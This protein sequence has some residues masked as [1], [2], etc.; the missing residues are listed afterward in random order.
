MSAREC[1][2]EGFLYAESSREQ[3]V[4]L[5]RDRDEQTRTASEARERFFAV[6]SHELRAALTPLVLAVEA[7]NREEHDPGKLRRLS[8]I[9]RNI[10]AQTRLVDDLLDM[11]R[12]L[13]Q[14]LR[15]VRRGCDLQ[16]LAAE[17]W[18]EHEPLARR[19]GIALERKL[20][21][22][23]CPIDADP[24]R[25]QQVLRN[26]LSNAIKFTPRGGRVLLRS[27]DAAPGW[28][29]LE[30]CDSGR[31]FDTSQAARVF[32]PFEQLAPQSEAGEPPGLGLGL[33]IAKG[34]VEAHGGAIHAHS[35]GPGSGA[36]FAFELPL[37]A[38]SPGIPAVPPALAGGRASRGQYVLV[39]ED[40]HDTAQ[41]LREL[42]E[43]WGYRVRLA[44]SVAE[45]VREAA[46]GCDV[47]LSDL[48]LPDGSGYELL[49]L[50]PPGLPALAMSGF[51]SDADLVRSRQAGFVEHLIKPVSGA[52]L[53]ISLARAVARVKGSHP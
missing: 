21:D 1:S 7:L 50:L 14:Q 4:A 49:A 36:R 13:R 44:H 3:L 45:A 31:G 47:V 53:L 28:A 34:I 15:L 2:K 51:G 46:Y 35:S 17:T 43:Q 42:L 8:I 26:L 22:A 29:G 27:Y 5:L 33:A 11:T 24:Q 6:L 25:I 23:P 40:H 39:V 19:R 16:R 48:S 12:L 18:D 41:A 32:E 38:S 52:Q 20:T 9:R 30:V 10:E 37:A